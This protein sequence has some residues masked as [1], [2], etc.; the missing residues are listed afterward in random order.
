MNSILINTIFC[1]VGL[2]GLYFGGEKLVTGAVTTANKL[3]IRPQ[4]VAITIV[5]LGTSLPELFVSVNAVN[6]GAQDIAWGNVVG[7]NISNLFCVL[8]FAAIVSPLLITSKS[9]K[10]EVFWVFFSCGVLVFSARMFSSISVLGG[11]L[12]LILLL[13]I[14]FHVSITALKS[15]KNKTQSDIDDSWKNSKIWI[16]L[17]TICFGALLLIGSAELVVFSAKK[18]AEILVIPEAFI[19]LTI[20]ALGTSLPEVAAS[21]VAV[22]R[23]HSDIAIGNV[24]GSNIFNS[25]G[26]IGAA[27]IASG[28]QKFV[29]PENFVR[30]DI[31]VMF[32]S[33][34]ILGVIFLYAKRIGRRTGAIFVFTYLVYVWIAFHQAQI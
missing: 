26:I 11:A 24:I 10:V 19:G 31:L 3:N 21:I 29:A 15:Q 7:S 34:L 28:S 27:A 8:G 22:Q 14:I 23:G 25:L 16:S 9:L 32:A 18:I 20:I 33:T 17:L 13:G 1:L 4:L 5:A 2:A 6:Q 30:F 12:L